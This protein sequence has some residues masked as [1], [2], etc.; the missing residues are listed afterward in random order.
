MKTRARLV[1][2]AALLLLPRVAEAAGR[3]CPGCP[4]LA[5]VERRG[6]LGGVV[7]AAGEPLAGLGVALHAGPSASRVLGTATTDGEGRFSLTYE[8]PG[9]GT[10]V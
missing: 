6:V 9:A 1:A 4:R 5:H 8:V 10:P 2:V 7:E 3:P